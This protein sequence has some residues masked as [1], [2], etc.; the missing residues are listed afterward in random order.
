VDATGRIAAQVRRVEDV[1]LGAAGTADELR[2]AAAEFDDVA[3]ALAGHVA[4]FQL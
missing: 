2:A 4:A 1:A 3:T